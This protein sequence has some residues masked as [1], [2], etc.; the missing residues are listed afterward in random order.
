MSH[1]NTAA[2]RR[3]FKG[4]ILALA[5]VVLPCLPGCDFFGGCNP[6][7]YTK[8]TVRMLGKTELPIDTSITIQGLPIGKI[9][10]VENNASGEQHLLLCIANDQAKFLNKATL[11]YADQNDSG[12]TLVCVPGEPKEA[13]VSKEMLFLGFPSYTEM[14]NW[15][16]KTFLK[17]G[18]QQFLDAIDNALK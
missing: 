16:T 18:M 10:K 9:Q 3:F 8:A 17:Q 14:L 1:P 12:K 5:L 15:K 6:F 2:R 4:L 13:P 7:S 11:F